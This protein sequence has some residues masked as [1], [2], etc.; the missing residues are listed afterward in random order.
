MVST[1]DYADLEQLVETPEEDMAK[2]REEIDPHSQA[3]RS[4][5]DAS[6]SRWCCIYSCFLSASS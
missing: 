3:K 6:T 1:Q 2:V 4:N 5:V